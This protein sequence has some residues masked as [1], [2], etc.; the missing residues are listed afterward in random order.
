M[1]NKSKLEALKEGKNIEF[2]KDIAG[3]TLLMK[4]K[5]TISTFT[6]RNVDKGFVEFTFTSN[7]EHVYQVPVDAFNLVR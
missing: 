3:T 5:R 4:T 7:P 6:C 1:I 2:T